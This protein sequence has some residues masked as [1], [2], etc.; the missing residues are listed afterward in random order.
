MKDLYDKIYADAEFQA[1]QRVRSRFSWMLAALMFGSFISFILVIAFAPA[2]LGQPLGPNTVISWGIPVAVAIIVFG[3]VLTGW[4]V[5]RA[6]GEFD[7]RIEAI[8]DRLN[9]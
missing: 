1:L 4:Y 3:F 2:L 5:W 9:N 6:N 8:V 7:T